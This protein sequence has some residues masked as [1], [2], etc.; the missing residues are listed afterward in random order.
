MKNINYLKQNEIDVDQAI[1]LLGDIEMYQETLNDFLEGTAE[2]I[3]KLEKYLKNQDMKDYAI[4]VHAMKSDSKYL[5]FTTLAD[6]AL[7]HQQKSENN[8]INYIN[9]HYKE[10]KKELDRIIKVVKEYLNG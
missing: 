8:D 10:L 1:E 3:P 2:R 6:L 9:N 4:E 7:E 5:G